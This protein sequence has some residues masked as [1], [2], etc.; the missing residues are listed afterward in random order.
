MINSLK[1]DDVYMHNLTRSP[2]Q[3]QA[4][5]WNY[6]NY[7][8]LDKHWKHKSCYDGNFVVSGGTTGYCYGNLCGH[9]G[10]Q[11]WHPD[12]SVFSEFQW[13]F[14]QY[15]IIFFHET[16]LVN[17]VCENFLF[18]WGSN[19]PMYPRCNLHAIHLCHSVHG[20]SSAPWIYMGAEIIQRNRINMAAIKKLQFYDI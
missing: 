14:N 12:D 4:I 11:S 19:V 2:I 1:L 8:H 16:A 6:L 5:N 17:N 18:I 7:C 15:T 3:C 10:P 13:N 9:Q 20:I